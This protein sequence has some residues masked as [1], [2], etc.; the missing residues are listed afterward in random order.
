[1]ADK[2]AVPISLA[3]AAFILLVREEF[4]FAYALI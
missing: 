3:I 4:A 2:S 1:L